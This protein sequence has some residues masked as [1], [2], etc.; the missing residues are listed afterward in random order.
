MS[1]ALILLAASLTAAFA[2][3]YKKA[4]SKD[5]TYNDISAPAQSKKS[6]GMLSVSMPN[7]SA[8]QAFLAGPQSFNSDELGEVYICDTLNHAVQIYSARGAFKKTVQRSGVDVTDR[9]QFVLGR[10]GIGIA[11]MRP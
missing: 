9:H 6:P 10:M 7:G 2:E 5:I 11:M 3:T 1:A 4:V 8:E